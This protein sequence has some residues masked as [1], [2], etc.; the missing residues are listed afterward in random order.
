MASPFRK[1][2]RRCIVEIITLLSEG[3]DAERSR[4]T[5]NMVLNAS[6]FSVNRKVPNSP[7]ACLP[8]LF[9]S[10]RNRI[11][12]I[13]VYD[14]IRYAARQA[15]Y[16][17]PAPVAST[18]S[19]RFC[20]LRKLF[21]NSV[22]ASYWQS[23]NPFLR[24]VGNPAKQSLIPNRLTNSYGVGIA[25]ICLKQESCLR[26]SQKYNSFPFEVKMKGSGF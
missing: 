15:V 2:K 8:R 16:V 20:P 14:S 12:L 13:G 25:V 24:K 19:A 5:V 7:S 6:P 21:S 22:T 9:L 23:R 1:E 11:L 10:T 3:I 26:K 4:F 18:I 17:L